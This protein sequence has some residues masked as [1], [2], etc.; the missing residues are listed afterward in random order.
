MILFTEV[1]LFLK[2]HFP[3]LVNLLPVVTNSV[4]I[5]IPR[6]RG[7]QSVVAGV[8]YP[9]APPPSLPP[10]APLIGHTRSFHVRELFYFPLF[11]L[12]HSI[13]ADVAVIVN[14]YQNRTSFGVRVRVP[15][16]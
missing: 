7:E 1:E 6:E 3:K 9:P 15:S 5:H 4:P 10:A 2:T 16:K 13:P 8:I 12:L 14:I 11:T